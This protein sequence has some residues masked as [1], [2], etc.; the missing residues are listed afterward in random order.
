MPWNPSQP[1][2][3]SQV[4]S[5]RV[6][7]ASVKRS[8]GRSESSSVTSV[9]ETSNSRRAPAA[10]LARIRSLTISVCELDGQDVVYIA[11]VPTKRIMTVTISVGT[12]FPAYATSM[13]RILLAE[14]R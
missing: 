12:R 14:F 11:R 5:C 9:P 4:T 3:A 2:I 6:P 7:V 13:G 8:T 10:S 1:A